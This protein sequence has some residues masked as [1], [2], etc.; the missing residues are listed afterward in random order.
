MLIV[1]FGDSITAGAYL[2]EEERFVN[3]LG[4]RLGLEVANAGVPGNTSTQGIARMHA[5]VMERK[6]DICIVAFGMNDHVALSH[7]QSKVPLNDFKSNLHYICN[8]IKNIGGTPVLCT[9]HPVI[10]GDDNGYYYS[11]HPRNWYAEPDGV[12]AWIDMY[13]QTIRELAVELN[14]ALAD[15]DVAWKLAI[16]Q[17]VSPTEL[18]RTT[19]NS[20]VSDG[21]HPT[22]RGQEL[23]AECIAEVIRSLVS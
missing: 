18:L 3:K 1:G 15:V 14:I 12:A 8:E 13:N 23:Y 20:A 16:E 5:D 19:E 10:E 17:G 6:P 7:N 9:I 22:E 4:Q 11:R 21:V 2:N